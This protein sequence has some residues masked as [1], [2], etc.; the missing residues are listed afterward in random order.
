MKSIFDKTGIRSRR[1]LV[2]A[3]LRY[4]RRVGGEAP[5][6]ALSAGGLLAAALRIG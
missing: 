5:V 4:R 1:E 2:A 6:P 3:I